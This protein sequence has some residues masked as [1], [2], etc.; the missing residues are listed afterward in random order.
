MVVLP[1]VD[2]SARKATEHVRA[3]N[4]TDWPILR[5]AVVEMYS[6]RDHFLQN[7]RSWLDV[8]NA[9]LD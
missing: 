3:R 2:L 4:Y 8:W 7:F 1:G 9:F 6:Y 5:A